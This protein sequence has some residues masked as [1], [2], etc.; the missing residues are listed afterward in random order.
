MEEETKKNKPTRGKVGRVQYK[1]WSNKD[2]KGK[3]RHSFDVYRS[4]VSKKD[5]QWVEKANF[6]LD[7]V[8]LLRTALD[9]VEKQI[10]TLAVTAA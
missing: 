9:E 6:S 3:T 4:Y 2:D 5:G 8:K 7:D 10:E 1:I